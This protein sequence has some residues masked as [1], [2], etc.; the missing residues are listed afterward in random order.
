M[1]KMLTTLFLSYFCLQ[2]AI[3]ATDSAVVN[4]LTCSK[5]ANTTQPFI[6]VL[7]KGDDLLESITHCAKDAKLLGAA[8]SALGQVQNPTLAYFTSDPKD[9]PT[10]TT[11]EGFYELASLTGNIAVN[12]NGYYT[13]VHGVL[14]DKEFHGIAGHVESSKVGLTVEVTITPFAGTVERAV[15]PDTGFGP[16]IH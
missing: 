1:K 3:G 11:F 15:D 4:Q 14:A 8:V 5:L 7:D 2:S 16:I 6:L 13:H 10:L 12:G 9:K